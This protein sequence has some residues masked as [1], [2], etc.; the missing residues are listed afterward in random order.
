MEKTS[1]MYLPCHAVIAK[2]GIVVL[3]EFLDA[4]QAVNMN[5]INMRFSRQLNNYIREMSCGKV[6]LEVE[7]KNN[8]DIDNVFEKT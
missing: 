1:H 4:N 3:V 2:K 5:F 8:R 7:H 6:T